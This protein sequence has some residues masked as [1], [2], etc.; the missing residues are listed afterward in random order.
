MSAREVGESP[1]SAVSWHKQ[2]QLAQLAQMYLRRHRLEHR[3][4]RFD[5]VAVT[6][7]AAGRSTISHIRNAF[8]AVG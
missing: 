3:R 6:L 2:R 7:D 8:D 4:C 1:A 5:V